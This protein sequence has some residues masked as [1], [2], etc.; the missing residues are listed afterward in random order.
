MSPQG[1]KGFPTVKLFPRGEEQAPIL[2]E[3]PDRSASAFF[4]FASQRV[5]QKN[6]K[7]HTVEE[8]EPWVNDVRPSYFRYPVLHSHQRTENRPNASLVA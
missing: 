5:P 6:K 1:V 4:Y 2:F 8:I 7:L 3:H